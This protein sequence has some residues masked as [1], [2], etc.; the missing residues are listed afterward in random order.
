MRAWGSIARPKLLGE[1]AARALGRARSRAGRPTSRL[2]GED[3]VLGHRHHGDEHEVLVHH[4]DP[5]PDRVARR[6]DAHG[7]A[8][9]RISPSSGLVEPVE[10]VHQRR[11]P[12]AVLAEQ[13]VHLAAAEVEVDAVVGDDPREPLGDPPQL[14]DDGVSLMRRDSRAVESGAR[15]SDTVVLSSYLNAEDRRD[16]DLALG[17]CLR[18][19]SSSRERSRHLL[20]HGAEPDGAVLQ[21]VDEVLPPFCSRR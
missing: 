19:P 13:R 10:D 17:I 4:A 5:A 9:D 3:D 8:V 16:L 11:L 15:P 21:G 20:V 2:D 7:L 18:W 14:E 12:G 6:V 1:L